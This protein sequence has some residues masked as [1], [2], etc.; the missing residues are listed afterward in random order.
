[1]RIKR[2]VKTG[3][4]KTCGMQRKQDFKV[5]LQAYKLMFKGRKSEN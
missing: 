5:S 2:K 1:M 3:H 4:I